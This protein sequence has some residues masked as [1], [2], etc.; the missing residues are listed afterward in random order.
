MK[1]N[2]LDI[3]FLWF[4]IHVR[5]EQYLEGFALGGPF[6]DSISLA[7]QRLF[8]NGLLNLGV[9]SARYGL[10]DPPILLVVSTIFSGLPFLW[11]LFSG[12]SCGPCLLIPCNQGDPEFSEGLIRAG[13]KCPGKS[14]PFLLVCLSTRN[15]VP[16]G[17]LP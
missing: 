3:Y 9:I 4:L 12:C 15:K 16:T 13:K 8:Q 1:S 17:S 14:S 11:S 5:Y 7:F 6:K 10:P 2:T